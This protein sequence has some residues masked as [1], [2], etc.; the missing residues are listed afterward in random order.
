MSQVFARRQVLVTGAAQGLGVGIA[1]H[2]ALQ[3]ARVF[4]SDCNPSVIDRAEEPIFERRASAAVVDLADADSM[5]R[6]VD[7]ATEEFGEIN[8]LVNCAA[9]SF[10]KPVA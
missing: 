3:G 4:L 1:R 6:L 10:H 7:Q 8:G 5:L 9:W 2:L